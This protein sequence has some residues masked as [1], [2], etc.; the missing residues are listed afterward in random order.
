MILSANHRAMQS[1]GIDSMRYSYSK[2]SN[3]AKFLAN[4]NADAADIMMLHHA[5]QA[6]RREGMAVSQSASCQTVI[7]RY[8]SDFPAGKAWLTDDP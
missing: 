6:E 3:V 2:N 5:A 7:E 4:K 8:Y 1:D